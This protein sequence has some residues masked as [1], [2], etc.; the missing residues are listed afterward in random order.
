MPVGRDSQAAPSTPLVQVVDLVKNF[1]S[2]AGS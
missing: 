1:P 2:G